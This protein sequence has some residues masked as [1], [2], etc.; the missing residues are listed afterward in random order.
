MYISWTSLCPMDL[1]LSSASATQSL[2]HRHCQTL[3]HC[4]NLLPAGLT[5]E[6][7]V[8]IIV[9]NFFSALESTSIIA[10][11]TSHGSAIE[12]GPACSYV[13]LYILLYPYKIVGN[14]TKS[15]KVGLQWLHII[16]WCKDATLDASHV[17]RGHGHTDGHTG[18][19]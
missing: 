17:R 15:W 18:S 8:S 4:S 12:I 14:R 7:T 3:T 16:I 6:S 9:S 19:C 5:K 13:S 11:L 2:R 10:V 1:P